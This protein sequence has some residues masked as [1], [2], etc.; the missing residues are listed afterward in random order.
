MKLVIVESPAKAKTINK[1]LG[2]DYKVIASFGH[3]RDLPSK[4]GSVVPEEN[5]AMKY[6]PSERATKYVNEIMKYAKKASVI[7]L[8]TDPDREGEAISWHVTEILKH[9][10]IVTDDETF[11]RI[12]FNEI[13]KKAVLE[14]VAN[15]RKIDTNLVN[16]QQARRALDYLVGFTLSP[17]LWRTLSGCKSAGRVQSV[18]LR[19]ICERENEIERFKNQEFWD[20]KLD[21]ANS[22]GESFIATLSRVDGN[23]LEK[24]SITNAEQAQNITERL[25]G[26]DFSVLAIQKKQQKRSPAAPFITSSLQQE[27]SRKLGFGAKKTM[28]VAQ[29]LYEGIEIEGETIG[30]ITYMRTDGV[31]LSVDAV[32]VIRALIQDKYGKDYLYDTPRLYKS[33]VKNAQEAHEAIRPT[34]IRLIPEKLSQQLDNDQ[35]RLYDLIW[36]RTIACQ[37]ENVVIDMVGADIISNDKNFIARATGSTIVFDGFYKVYQEGTDDNKD[38][39]RKTLPQLS[40]LELIET[41]KIR[42]DQH[43]TEPPP[44]Y[45]EASL[46]KRLEEL[47]I[48]RPS[49]YASIISVLQERKYVI[50]DK[51]RF[52]PNDLGRL[53][54]TFLTGFFSKYVEYDFTANLEADLDKIAEGNVEWKQVLSDFWLGFNH[55]IEQVKDQNIPDIILYIERTLD[56]H[57]FGASGTIEYEKNRTC[58]SCETGIL[59][60][61]LS[62][63]GSF[64]GCDNYPNCTYKKTISTRDTSDDDF[65]LENNIKELGTNEQSV[66]IYLKSGPYGLYVQLGD[67]L[68]KKDKP[69]R[70][71][72]PPNI[73]PEDL[74]LDK[75][76]E[77]LSLPKDIGKHSESGQEI[78][79]GLGRFG[80]YVKHDN[81][82]TSIPKAIDPFS[83]TLSQAEELIKE[84]LKRK[85]A[86]LLATPDLSAIKV[87]SKVK[88][89]IKA[90]KL[91]VKPALKTTI[92]KPKAKIK[93][94]T[95]TKK[96]VFRSKTKA[97][98]KSNNKESFKSKITEPITVIKDS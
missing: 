31:T 46:V 85:A 50:V 95:K 84:K 53:V 17:V 2:S 35:M 98:P 30:L 45:S 71:Q 27:A 25:A 4:K 72:L 94:V 87:T 66:P 93:T 57:L 10:K 91:K 42:P 21:M 40:E 96:P 67:A 1:Y 43:F 76:I 61:K 19:I 32:E 23:K 78:Q 54:T 88:T 39:D 63:Y 37:M 68:S 58:V 7:Y 34:D 60:L 59:H 65:F 9:E 15:P 82:F 81:Q 14:A 16:A 44:R 5:F 26:Q 20:I 79:M 8:A 49:T 38:E 41:T 51:K 92:S 22:N 28:Q 73:K 56:F 77:L 3:I 97:K 48:G 47:G 55:N 33:K 12:A 13:T 74:S 90:K 29:K 6:A 89:A 64:L 70:C 75:A 86:K 36:K 24:F 18:A 62:K 11:K 83:I 69:K 52:Y 80:P